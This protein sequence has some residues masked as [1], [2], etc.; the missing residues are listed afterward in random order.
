MKACDIPKAFAQLCIHRLAIVHTSINLL[1]PALGPRLVGVVPA[2]LELPEVVG[3]TSIVVEPVV[4]G[5]A[6]N[7][8]LLSGKGEAA[9][10]EIVHDGRDEAEGG[11]TVEEEL[12]G[13][14]EGPSDGVLGHV[15]TT[16]RGGEVNLLGVLTVGERAAGDTV[17]V[18]TLDIETGRAEAPAGLAE[19]FELKR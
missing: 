6:G 8:L 19:H 14:V 4:G 3:L 12:E 16:G 18:E 9:N 13:G 11:N 7:I 1:E 15:E 5:L 10:E 17:G 2:L